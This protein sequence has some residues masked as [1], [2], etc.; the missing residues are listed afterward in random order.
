MMTTMLVFGAGMA[1]Y[2]IAQRNNM[3]SARNIKKMS[4]KVKRAFL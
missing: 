3:M 1:T 4:K 2:N